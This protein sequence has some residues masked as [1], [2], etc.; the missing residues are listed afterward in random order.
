M[1]KQ[2]KIETMEVTLIFGTKIG[3]EVEWL[4]WINIFTNCKTQ[5]K[6]QYCGKIEAQSLV[7]TMTF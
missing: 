4:S 7:A 5:N 2:G 3:G 1:S 6:Y